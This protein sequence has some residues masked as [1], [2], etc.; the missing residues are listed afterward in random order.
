[1]VIEKVEGKQDEVGGGPAVKIK[2]EGG[3][4]GL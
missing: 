4:G 2:S 1:M 3:V